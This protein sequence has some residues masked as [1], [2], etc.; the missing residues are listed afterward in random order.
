MKTDPSKDK[1]TEI[2]K[3]IK[4]EKMNWDFEDFLAET[5]KKEKIIPIT[6][7]TEGGSF[8]KIFWMAASV[9]LLVA[10]GILFKYESGNTMDEK[11]QMV[12][13]EIL[14]QKDVFQKDSQLAINQINDSLKIKP[15]SIISD[16]TRTVEQNSDT[17]I[18]EQLIPK[19]GR[20]NRA[21]RVRYAEISAPKN[22]KTPKYESNYVI[23]NGQK[24]ENEQ[25]AIDLTKYSFRILSENVS[26]TMAQTEVIN[27]F[28]N[29]Y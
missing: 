28:N 26:K 1:Y 4:E 17:D 12:Q 24:I 13:N 19:R 27:S 21:S 15:D 9:V 20:I 8:S 7:K 10:L 11:N 2:L 5:E 6:S 14:K 18:M 23:I 29:D 22:T 3:E 16:S 25:E